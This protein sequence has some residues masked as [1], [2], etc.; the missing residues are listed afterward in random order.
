MNTLRKLKTLSI[1]ERFKKDG[2]VFSVIDLDGKDRILT[3]Q[4]LSVTYISM[5]KNII[6]T[7]NSNGPCTWGARVSA[8]SE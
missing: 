3:Q 8:K 5:D 6:V 4:I 2:R 1:N 7:A